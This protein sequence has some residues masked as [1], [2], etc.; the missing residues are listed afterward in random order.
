M[1]E[2]KKSNILHLDIYIIQINDNIKNYIHKNFDWYTLKFC[3]YVVSLSF[4]I[5]LFYKSFSFCAH[6]SVSVR[7]AEK[8]IFPDE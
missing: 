7:V 1:R 8:T 6:F 2:K 5:S 3:R 4:L